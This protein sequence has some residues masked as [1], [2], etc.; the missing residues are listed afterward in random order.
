LDTVDITKFRIPLPQTLSSHSKRQRQRKPSYSDGFEGKEV[1]PIGRWMPVRF[2]NRRRENYSKITI[3][4]GELTIV[5]EK[6]V[7]EDSGHRQ[8]HHQKKHGSRAKQQSGG[9]RPDDSNVNSP[10]AEHGEDPMLIDDQPEQREQQVRS[11]SHE[12][13]FVEDR[14]QRTPS[15][16]TNDFGM[17]KATSYFYKVSTK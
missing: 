15:E 4:M 5:A 1:E 8:Q 10:Q 9:A 14:D 13:A 11:Q 12:A 6:P 16:T 7:E 2:P 17:S 3:R